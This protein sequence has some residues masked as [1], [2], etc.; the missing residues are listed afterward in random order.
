[1][2]P[3][4][5]RVAL[6]LSRLP[7]GGRAVAVVARWCPRLLPFRVAVLPHLVLLRHPA[8]MDTVHLLAIPRRLIRDV[9]TPHPVVGAFWSD[10]ENWMLGPGTEHGIAA[11][12]TNVGARQD[13]R[14][15]HVHL[16][17]EVPDWCS[18]DSCAT[19][20]HWSGQTLPHAMA[21]LRDCVHDQCASVRDQQEFASG[22]FGFPL[23][24]GTTFEVR[25]DG[26]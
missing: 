25:F 3:S 5:R 26:A 6:R 12:I 4:L 13:V 24:G 2:I 1:M 15:L 10:L 19:G 18:P 8:P 7:I 17:S 20:R 21:R 23:I 11:G 9:R 16:V 14:L 22:S